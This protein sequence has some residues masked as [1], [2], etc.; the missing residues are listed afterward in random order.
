[1]QIKWKY[2]WIVENNTS[3][4]IKYSGKKFSSWGQNDSNKEEVS[5]GQVVTCTFVK[6]MASPTLYCEHVSSQQV[7][8]ETSLSESYRNASFFTLNAA[9]VLR[10]LKEESNYRFVKYN[11]K[12][13]K[14]QDD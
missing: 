8:P 12:K 3:E 13:K 6:L 5:R 1:M 2:N 9:L 7:F 14:S 4:D 11:K 10:K